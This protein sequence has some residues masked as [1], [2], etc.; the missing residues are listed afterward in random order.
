VLELLGRADAQVKVRGM[1]VELGE[2]EHALEGHPDVREAVVTV[3][4][5]DD[6][7]LVAYT[8]APAPTPAPSELDAFLRERLPEYMVPRAFVAVDAWPRTPSGKIDRKA[9]PAPA[10]GAPPT[11]DF[12]APRSPLEETVARVWSDVLGVER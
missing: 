6:G 7:A 11:L 9:L 8:L 2:I 1:R 12:V 3:S 10:L 5:G 4:N